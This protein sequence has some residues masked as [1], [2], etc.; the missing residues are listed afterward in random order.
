MSHPEQ[1]NMTLKVASNCGEFLAYSDAENDSLMYRRVPFTAN[2]GSCLSD[3]ESCIYDNSVFLLDYK[4]VKISFESMHFMLLP[5]AVTDE[6]VIEQM[7]ELG[8]PT[9]E[10]EIEEC[11][12]AKCKARIVY[13]SASGVMSFLRRTFNNPVIVHHLQPVVEGFQERRA[14]SVISKMYVYLRET[15]M[16]VC[17]FEQGELTIANTFD[18]NNVEDASYYVLNVWQTRKLDAQKDE[19]QI[20]GSRVVRESLSPILREYIRYVM[21]AMF[22]PKA[23]KL[24]RD[25]IKAPFDLITLS[26]CE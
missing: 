10:G 24:G 20:I 12:L 18:F 22:P 16:D 7:M 14:S 9:E 4:Q 5:Q 6:E 3:L 11:E 2:T 1:W 13:Y 19:L 21:P 26:I 8:F 25:A 23:M 15:S 17:V